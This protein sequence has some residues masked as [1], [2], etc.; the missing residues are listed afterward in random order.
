M[1]QFFFN[2]EIGLF[3]FQ[4]TVKPVYKG[5]SMEPENVAF[6]CEQLF[7]IDRLK[8]YNYSL[9]GKIRLPFID[10]DLLYTSAI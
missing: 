8:L 2:H 9:M 3:Y 10:S 4:T 5:H 1:T 7:F 6:V